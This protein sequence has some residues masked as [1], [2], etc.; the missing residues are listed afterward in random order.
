MAFG[1][2]CKAS[3]GVGGRCRLEHPYSTNWLSIAHTPR[4]TMTNPMADGRRQIR[5]PGRRIDL[6]ARDAC[7]S[8]GGPCRAPRAPSAGA[9]R[10][11]GGVRPVGVGAMCS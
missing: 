1:Q 3:N 2:S 10:A 6:L 5:P 11:P 4:L 8:G 9:N 7:R